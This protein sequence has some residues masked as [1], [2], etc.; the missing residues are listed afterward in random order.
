MK[1]ARILYVGYNDG[2]QAYY[3]GRFKKY[4]QR[5]G[6]TGFSSRRI[7]SFCKEEFETWTGYK[8]KN[9]ECRKIQIQI[10]EVK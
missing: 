3:L 8:L 1:K 7:T 4:W 2:E 10:K 6:Y 9:G 5:D